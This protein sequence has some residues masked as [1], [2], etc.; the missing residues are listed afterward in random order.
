MVD[1]VTG[2]FTLHPVYGKKIGFKYFQ[3]RFGFLE[4]L[5][6]TVQREVLVHSPNTQKWNEISGYIYQ[7][8][9]MQTDKKIWKF[10]FTIRDR[11][12]WF[13]KAIS[14]T[15]PLKVHK[16][17]NFF[18]SDFEFCTISLLVMLKY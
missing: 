13:K 15:L 3:L 7:P 2:F 12:E 17:E 9:S 8:I 18:G 6:Y 1:H 16:N 5:D 14:A 4:V 11:M 10:Q